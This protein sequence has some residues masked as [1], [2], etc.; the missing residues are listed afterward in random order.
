MPGR[1]TF[2][3]GYIVSVNVSVNVNVN[4]VSVVSVLCDVLNVVKLG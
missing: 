4:V 3:R 2:C 1:R